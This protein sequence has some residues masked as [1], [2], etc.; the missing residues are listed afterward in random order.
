MPE[1]FLSQDTSSRS[2]GAQDVE[3]ALCAEQARAGNFHLTLTGS[4]GAFFLEPLV[5]VETNGVRVGYANVRAED[6]AGLLDQGLLE[7]RPIQPFYIGAV[8]EVP[9]LRGQERITFRNCGVVEAGSLTAYLKTGGGVALRRALFELDSQAIIAE[10]KLS[11]LRGR[12]G[13]AFPTGVKWQ[14]V[15]ECAAGVKYVVAN[16]D[17]GDPGTYADRMLMEGDP[18][19]LIEGM[20]ICARAVGAHEGF[21]Y[22][23]AEYPRAAAAMQLAVDAARDA[24]YLGHDILGSGFAFDVE[25]RRGG[26]AYVCGEETALLES[27]EGKRGMVRPKP[28]YPATIGLFGQPTVINNVTTL[29]TIPPI[30]R[31][32][33]AWYAAL[34]AGRS[35]GTIALQLAGSLRTPGLVEVPF[36]VTLR[37]VIDTYGGGV[38]QGRQLLAVQVGGPLGDLLP[39]SRL[40]V[41]IDFDAFTEIGSMLGHGG[42]VVYDDRTQPLELARRLMAYVAHESCGK[43]APC[44]LGSQRAAEILESMLRG[45]GQADDLQLIDDIA[46]AMRGSSLCALGAM[47]P[48]PV[49][50]AIRLFPE[51]FRLGAVA[52]TSRMN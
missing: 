8:A 16:G 5:E 34:G 32:G 33:G 3:A 50:S 49:L 15:A 35:R 21:I 48:T 42:I 47:A 45:A 17:E 12:G 7:G 13:A 1:V 26:G 30:L 19:A 6:V 10:V 52:P 37:A 4:R 38:P 51:S 27:L 31:Q 46:F 24:G 28:P 29:A 36:G 43:C 20:A 39:A 9:F 40:D 23:R 18:F 25:I 44:R 41:P 11:G 2:I 14:T 22:I